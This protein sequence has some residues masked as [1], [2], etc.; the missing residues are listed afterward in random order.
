MMTPWKRVVAVGVGIPLALSLHSAKAAVT[1]IP[2]SEARITVS[3]AAEPVVDLLPELSKTGEPKLA[4][5][6]ELGERRVHAYV[7][8]VPPAAARRAVAMVVGGVWMKTEG[9]PTLRLEPDA[10]V[11]REIAAIQSARKQRFFAGLQSLPR[12]L[13][14]DAAGLERLRKSDPGT[15]LSL[16]EPGNRAAVQLLGL[17]GKAHWTALEQAGQ[18]EL[19]VEQL[20]P[21]GAVG[22]RRYVALMNEARRQVDEQLPPGEKLDVPLL[23]ADVAA[24]GSLEFRVMPS[25]SGAP[26]GDLGIG[27]G[28]GTTA[29]FMRVSGSRSQ[30]QPGPR[31]LDRRGVP[32]EKL[33]NT[34]A[35][36]RLSRIPGSWE[37]A[38]RLA[39]TEGGLN[40]VSEEI[41]RQFPLPPNLGSPP[42]GSAAEVLDALCLAFGYQWRYEGGIYRFRSA[43]WYLERATEPPGTLVKAVETA[44][45]EKRNLE[46]P[47]LAAAARVEPA[48]LEKLWL[49]APAAMPVVVRSQGLLRFFGALPA[50]QRLALTE[51]GGLPAQKLSPEQRHAL[52]AILRTVAPA[53][54]AET[55]ARATLRLEETKDAA[56]WVFTSEA[57]MVE[58]RVIYPSPS[59]ASPFSRGPFGGG[60]FGPPPGGFPMPPGGF[61]PPKN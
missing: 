9:S 39:S 31:W 36:I 45:K 33:P 61:T 44:R 34:Q 30:D 42:A 48:R 59:A 22:I 60:A 20:G 54:P 21:E 51:A 5:H 27:L 56:R 43:A 57:G 19:Q 8:S 47:W 37:E 32:G 58:S 4:A 2:A 38:L 16:S 7:R 52:V 13:S 11:T 53:W 18:L 26:F 50:E 49:H 25:S 46:L 35:Q 29:Q 24:R 10:A 3:V 23:D 14:L 6:P 55:A 12:Q 15:A 17:L 1:A 28:D 40:L 41:T